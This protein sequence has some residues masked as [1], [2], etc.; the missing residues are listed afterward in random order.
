MAQSMHSAVA[1]ATQQVA[2]MT[3]A[4]TVDQS[5]QQMMAQG[6]AAAGNP[7]EQQLR[8]LMVS[9][10]DSGNPRAL[11]PGQ[12]LRGGSPKVGVAR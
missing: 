8:D 7:I 4:A 2:A 6:A 1:Q 9:G 12:S 10:N 3:A 5:R 11:P